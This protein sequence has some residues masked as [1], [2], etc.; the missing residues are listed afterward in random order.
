VASRFSAFAGRPGATPTTVDVNALAADALALYQ[1]GDGRHV[2]RAEW[3]AP[4][5]CVHADRD[6][7]RRVLINLVTNAL[8]AMER[9]GTLL[10][11]TVRSPRPEPPGRGGTTRRVAA[12]AA[13]EA[14]AGWV[15][16]EIRDDGPGIA[17]EVQ[18]RLFEPYF[19][20]KSSGTG[21]G[22]WICR[23]TI[24]EM[25]GEISLTSALGVGT[26][27]WVWLPR[28]PDDTAAGPDAR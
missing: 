2:V 3:A 27:A 9:G 19:S 17:P 4:T 5:P 10:V 20:T 26:S 12:A 15:G 1:T 16:I 11:R 8:Q 6:D 23:S 7:L 18:A 24:E 22:L 14:P 28:L 21:L 25:G 13:A